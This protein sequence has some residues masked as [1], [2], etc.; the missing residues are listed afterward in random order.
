MNRE[1]LK[2]TTICLHQTDLDDEINLQWLPVKHQPWKGRLSTLFSP[3]EITA[4]EDGFCWSVE[5]VRELGKEEK[6]ERG[7]LNFL[8]RTFQQ[9]IPKLLAS[10][11]LKICQTSTMGP[12]IG[13]KTK[14]QVEAS[15]YN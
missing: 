6:T 3:V 10:N 8:T 9:V 1:A 5:E 12:Q 7:S 11:Q 2:A 14:E 13:H 4:S 15:K